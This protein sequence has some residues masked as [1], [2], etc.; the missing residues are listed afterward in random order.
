MR[1]LIS[2]MAL[3]LLI[4]TRVGASDYIGYLGIDGAAMTL[5]NRIG[6]NIEPVNLRLRLGGN[7]APFIDLEGHLGLTVNSDEIFQADWSADFV[8]LFIKGHLPLGRYLSLYGLAGLSA[9]TI[10]ET[11]GRRH[12]SDDR[13]GFAYGVGIESVISENVDI[14]LDYVNYLLDDNAFDEVSAVSFGFK[15]YY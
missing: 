14:S 2:S 5:E 8:A 13:G 10:T 3:L 9:V 1:F 15:I 7:V 6:E 4:S 12:F 11:I